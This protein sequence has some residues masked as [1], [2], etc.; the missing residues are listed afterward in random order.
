MIQSMYIHIP[1]CKSICTYCDFCKLFYKKEW[2]INYLNALER[3]IKQNYQ[4]EKIKTLYIG[5]GTPNC[6]SN[7]ELERLLNMLSNINLEDN[8]EYT[9]EC[10]I[11]LL[12]L[13]QV[14]L[15]KKYGVNRVSIGVQTV[16]DKF[17]KFLGRNHTKEDVKSKI[18][19]LKDNGINN[20][21]VDLIYAIPNQTLED[22]NDDISFLLQLEI[23]HISTY[24]LIIEPNTVLHNKNIQNIDEDL[25]SDMYNLIIDKLSNYNHYETS[26]F[27]LNGYESK[28][29][30][31]YW[32]NLNYYGFGLGASGYIKN[33]RYDNTRS[34][35]NYNM[36]KYLLSKVELTKNETIENEFI[37][38]FR[39]TSG[40]NIDDFNRKYNIDLLS[41]NKV[42]QLLEKGLIVSTGSN[43]RINDKYLYTANEILIEFIGEVYEK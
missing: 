13:E 11:E 36:G 20:I 15:F 29:N 4:E 7:E 38:G 17:L 41:V 34:L 14:K 35:T 1:F 6:L 10:N 5:G 9:I 43:I 30:L 28:H 24:S 8:Y 2:V 32:N 21:N 26:N 23:P 22:L 25:D 19:M 42:K 12:T 16:N 3:E 18:K 31:T 27:A 37:L 39:K 33:V 40:I